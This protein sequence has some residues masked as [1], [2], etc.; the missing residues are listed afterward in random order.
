MPLVIDL[1]LG[2]DAEADAEA[3]RLAAGLG[4]VG[5]E[6]FLRAV[7]RGPARL[8][9]RSTDRLIGPPAGS[10]AAETGAEAGDRPSAETDPESEAGD[11]P[12]ADPEAG[13]EPSSSLLLR[14]LHLA[15]TAHLPVGL[16]PDLLWY[17]V[18]HEVAT[19]IRLHPDTYAGLFTD[20]P[21]QRRTIRVRDDNAPRDWEHTLGLF[22]EPLRER[23]GA[24]VAELFRPSFSTTGRAEATAVLIA[25]M[26]A[27]SPYYRFEV[28]TLC[29]IPRIR[30]EGTDRDWRLLAARVRELGEWFEG[31]RPW[32]SALEPV[33]EEIAATASGWGVREE[34]WRSLYKWRSESSG[35]RVTG[36]IT[37]FLAHRYTEDGPLP[38]ES[39]G[40]G[41]LAEEDL[42]SHVSR[43]PFGWETPEGDRE[44][45]F[46]GGV[47]GIEDDDGWIRPRLG[48]AVA[49]PLTGA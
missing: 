49:E 33:L 5:N 38:R 37:A 12:S 6:A 46:L 17:A 7:L 22:Q 48:H 41:T 20:T 40:P 4:E 28:L 23:V 39:F 25:L 32:F 29:G 8:H 3:A 34:F 45:V 44:M 14:A 13:A 10:E 16:S 43:V 35:N 36:W 27:V 11:R 26:D 18:V 31:L 19:H 47:L 2:T 24:D 21:G 15:F 1:P 42:P 30:L 9:H